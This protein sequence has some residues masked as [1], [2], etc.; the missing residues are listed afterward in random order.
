[1]SEMTVPSDTDTTSTENLFSTVIQKQDDKTWKFSNPIIVDRHAEILTEDKS[2]ST[3]RLTSTENSYDQTTSTSTLV[4]F[5]TQKTQ[6]NTNQNAIKAFESF[7]TS[8]SLDIKRSKFQLEDGERNIPSQVQMNQTFLFQNPAINQKIDVR[9]YPQALQCWRNLRNQQTKRVEYELRMAYNERLIA[10]DHF[11]DWAVTFNPQANLLSTAKA[12]E[13]V[14][15]FRY[16]QAKMNISMLTD[17]MREE[18]IRLGEDIKATTAALESHYGNAEAKDYNLGEAIN[19]IQSFMT[20]TKENE[21]RELSKRYESL[22]A[23]P[24]AAIWKNLPRDIVS[25]PPAAVREERPT[26]GFSNLEEP[27]RQPRPSTW[28]GSGRRPTRG[29]GQRGS[30]GIQRGRGGYQ[31]GRRQNLQGI[32]NFLSNLMQ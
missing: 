18:S 30:R 25:P 2:T 32:M 4:R 9:V 13:A 29:R 21:E 14:A 3:S 28:R 10:T 24:L 1:M 22:Q 27:S 5:N 17:L 11:P 12:V 8:M 26:P 7:T 15:R 16:E 20:R 19:A 23:A 31:R 6:T